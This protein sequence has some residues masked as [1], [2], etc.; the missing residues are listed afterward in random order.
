MK[1]KVHLELIVVMDVKDNRKDT[2]ITKGKLRIAWDCWQM[3]GL[4]YRGTECLLCF[5]FTDKNRHQETLTW[6]S[7]VKD[8]WKTFP[9]LKRIGLEDLHKS[10]GPDRM[11]PWVLRELADTIPG[12]SPS[13][14]WQSGV[15]PEGLEESECHLSLQ[16]WQEREPKELLAIQPHL[17]PWEGKE[18]LILEPCWKAAL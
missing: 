1:A 11:D 6:E 4:D 2:S 15:V 9:W 10:M 16:K 5:V 3:K 17:S 14:L 7:R 8:C 12:H 18:Y 13:S